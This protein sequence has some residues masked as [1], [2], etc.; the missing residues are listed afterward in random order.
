MQAG[1]QI[2]YYFFDSAFISKLLNAQRERSK[3]SK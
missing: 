3:Q 2:R 1:L